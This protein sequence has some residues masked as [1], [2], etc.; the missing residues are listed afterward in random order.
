MLYP[1]IEL[2]VAIPALVFALTKVSATLWL[3]AGRG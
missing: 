2:G 3:A 1:A